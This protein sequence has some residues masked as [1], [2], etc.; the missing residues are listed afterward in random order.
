MLE[1]TIGRCNVSYVPSFFQSMP[2]L[3]PIELNT[4]TGII[5]VLLLV[6]AVLGFALEW[7]D[8]F[9]FLNPKGNLLNWRFVAAL[10][11]GT[12][13]VSWFVMHEVWRREYAAHH[14]VKDER[15]NYKA[16]LNLSESERMMD[17][18]TGVPNGAKLTADLP[19]FFT[20]HS[21]LS[22]AQIVLIDIKDFRSINRDFGFLKGDE[23]LRLVAQT[24]YRTM[25]RNEN[26]YKHPGEQS[27]GRGLRRTFY[28]RY[29]GGDEFVFLV[30]GD[31]SAAVGFV[32]RL[33][34]L[35]KG[36]AKEIEGILEAKRDLSFH[37]AIAPLM[38][39]DKAEDAFR[40]VEDCYR[41]SAEGTAPFTL[42]WSPNRLE[43][44]L[45]DGDYRKAF[46]TKAREVFQIMNMPG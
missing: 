13:V 29:P 11:V 10:V 33:V 25:R 12:N 18:V 41:R 30:D 5:G 38:K 39:G 22:E 2:G 8:I 1:N 7:K 15:D 14:R 44:Q 40:R 26:M 32:N 34:P 6:T 3:R 17:V 19:Q 23:V 21:G 37:C 28:R 45:K 36:L 42:C 24:I 35:F 4:K 16:L 20:E 46:Y 9:E 27:A 31:Q 43:P